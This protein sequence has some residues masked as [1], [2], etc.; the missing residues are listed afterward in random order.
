MTLGIAERVSKDVSQHY[1]TKH[2]TLIRFPEEIILAGKKTKYFT[3]CRFT[4]F[5]P[6]EYQFLTFPT[7]SDGIPLEWNSVSSVRDS[8]LETEITVLETEFV[9]QTGHKLTWFNGG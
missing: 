9:K 8:D 5:V 3:I 6:E 1:N 2:V 4:A 7:N